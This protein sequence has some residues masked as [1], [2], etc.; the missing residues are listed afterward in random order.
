MLYMYIYS[1][2]RVRILAVRV[3]IGTRISMCMSKICWSIFVSC[4]LYGP[5]CAC[6]CFSYITEDGVT[7]LTVCGSSYPKRL[8]FSFLE[9]IR[10]AFQEELQT[11]FGTHAVDYRSI[12]ETIE[13]PYYFVKFGR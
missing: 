7:F 4:A 9:D 10:A 8:A 2:A 11:A 1:S 3:C 6:M 5:L 13:K 12:I